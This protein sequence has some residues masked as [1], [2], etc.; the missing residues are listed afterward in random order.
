MHIFI[1]A[2]GFL[3]WYIAYASKPIIND[4]TNDLWK[5]ENI[6]KRN[7]LLNILNKSI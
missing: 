3:L 6:I 5:E 7:R 1:F 4:D 2:G